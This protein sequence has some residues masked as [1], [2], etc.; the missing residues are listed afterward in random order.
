MLSFFGSS[1]KQFSPDQFE[2]DLKN[3]S[4]R[5]TGTE[6]RI[7]SLRANKSYYSKV[8]PVYISCLYLLFVSYVY[9]IKHNRWTNN[10]ILVA[11]LS[12][13]LSFS[14]YYLLLY[15]LNYLIS[16][17]DL[18]LNGLRDQHREKLD[19]L[20]EQTNFYKTNE[21]LT[22]F[23]NGEDFKELELQ[24]REIEKKK[25][26]YLKLIKEGKL[27]NPS[28]LAAANGD[29]SDGGNKIYDGFLKFML[30]EDELSADARYALICCNCF[31]HNGLAPPNVLPQK[32]KYIC[33]K[34]GFLNGN[35]EE[36]KKE[37]VPV[38]DGNEKSNSVAKIS[39]KKS[40]D[41]PETQVTDDD[42]LDEIDDTNESA[43]S[44]SESEKPVVVAE[45]KTKKK[46]KRGHK[47][48]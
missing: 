31:Q 29:G 48:Q 1:T 37:K 33:P 13:A 5:I 42:D 12:P 3:L 6:K 39:N 22:R 23:S 2:K 28:K 30:G 17:N 16:T 11:V 38:V 4:H 36:E 40:I 18:A 41:K 9:F 14:T 43:T 32:V 19:E 15:T 20:K 27:P 8:L 47:K 25:Q 46:K 24:A 45:K 26:E 34:C 35:E 10:H 7:V 21:L 44:G